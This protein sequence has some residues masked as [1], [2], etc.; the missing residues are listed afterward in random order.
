M[1]MTKQFMMEKYPEDTEQDDRNSTAE[2]TEEEMI[3]NIVNAI[4]Y[5]RE[6]KGKRRINDDLIRY[7][8]DLLLSF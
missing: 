1:G 8:I 7:Q 6:A 2:V 5:M 3:G 4:H